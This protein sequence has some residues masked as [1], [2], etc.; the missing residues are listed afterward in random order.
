MIRLSVGTRHR[1]CHQHVQ[2][3]T[4]PDKDIIQQ[5]PVSRPEEQPGRLRL[6]RDC[7]QSLIL[8]MTRFFSSIRQYWKSPLSPAR[9]VG[10]ASGR[11]LMPHREAEEGVGQQE[12]VFRTGSQKKE[13]VI[14]TATETMGTQHSLPG[15]VVY[16]D[17]SVKDC[18]G[19]TPLHDA[20]SGQNLAMVELLLSDRADLTIT[21]SL[22][23]N[24]LHHGALVEILARACQHDFRTPF[25]LESPGA[26][27]SPPFIDPALCS[28][29]PSVSEHLYY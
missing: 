29:P 16:P 1:L 19:D 23:H 18:D 14:V 4:P 9:P 27:Y 26:C 17:A 12:T 20:I 13:A 11:R 5:A 22:G 7:R 6:L 25:E 15:S 28:A 3:V 24:C 2:F 10:H 8:E 21:N